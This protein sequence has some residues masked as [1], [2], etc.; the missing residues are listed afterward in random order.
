MLEKRCFKNLY[1]D[2]FKQE[3]REMP[4][5]GRILECQCASQ[6]AELFTSVGCLCTNIDNPKQK[7]LCSISPGNNK[8]HDGGKK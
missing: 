6:A 7:Q 2:V 3:I 8:K 5:L 1:K 4:E